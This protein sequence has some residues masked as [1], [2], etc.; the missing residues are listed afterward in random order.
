MIEGEPRF[1]DESECCEL[2]RRMLSRY[3]GSDGIRDASLL[4][5][6]LAT[7][8]AGMFGGNFHETIPAMAAALA[9]S[10]VRNHPFVDGNKRVGLLASEAFLQRNGF[11]L[12]AAK[13]ELIDLFLRLAAGE[14]TKD[15][16]ISWYESHSQRV[17]ERA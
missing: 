4:N 3:G 10:L 11:E 12:I 7:P 2:H 13:D 14:I 16:L 6:A 8:R 5:S 17:E 15:F 1:I 9:F